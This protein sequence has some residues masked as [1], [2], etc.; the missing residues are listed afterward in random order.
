MIASVAQLSTV[1]AGKLRKVKD[2]V[3]MGEGEGEETGSG[4]G[5]QEKLPG[6]FLSTSQDLN[7]YLSAAISSPGASRRASS[8]WGR[9]KN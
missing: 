2:D 7:P 5:S 9:G 6:W 1:K 4:S 8:P 3:V